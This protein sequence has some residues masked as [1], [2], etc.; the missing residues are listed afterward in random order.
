MGDGV[1]AGVHNAW[2]QVPKDDGGPRRLG[3][4]EIKVPAVS[5]K[6]G[7]LVALLSASHRVVFDRGANRMNQQMNARPSWKK[8]GDGPQ[9]RGVQR[10]ICAKSR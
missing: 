10:D 9:E 3:L 5:P 7:T 2:R 4:Q 8:E 1:R 6:A